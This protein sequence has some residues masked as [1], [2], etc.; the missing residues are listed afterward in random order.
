[1]T[2]DKINGIPNVKN[3]WGAPLDTEIYTDNLDQYICQAF[4]SDWTTL[5]DP[6]FR[7]L[8]K[9]VD[10]NGNLVRI[11]YARR[12]NPTTGQYEGWHKFELPATDLS[13]VSGYTYN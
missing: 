9:T 13:T 8:K 4:T 1:M 12:L 6:K 7:I 10:A 3:M 5:S 11:R 2:F